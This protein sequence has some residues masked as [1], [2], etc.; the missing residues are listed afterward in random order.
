MSGEPL[1]Q[2]LT[3]YI[4]TVVAAVLFILAATPETPG[5]SDVSFEYRGEKY[6]MSPY[7][8]LFNNSPLGQART[9]L[10]V[11]YLKASPEGMARVKKAA[12][13]DPAAVW[14]TL[15]A[16]EK[17]TFLAVTAAASHLVSERSGSTLSWFERL[18]Q[19]HGSTK[20]A[21]GTYPNNQAF[22][23]YIRLSQTG[24][25]HLK[26]GGEFTNTCTKKKVKYGGMG[27]KHPD[28]CNP[29]KKFQ[30]QRPTNNSPRLQINVTDASGCADVDL[31]YD[32]DNDEHLTKDNSNVLGSHPD[33]DPAEYPPHPKIFVEQYCDLGFRRAQP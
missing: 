30:R 28:F 7:T 20:P 29:G 33:R 9:N 6:L 25:A 5:Q 21:G 23:L 32:Y 31:D 2:R 10:F 27:S 13:G 3:P 8:V 17:T 19:I 11:E 16:E 18:E 14:A 4:V 22:R 1:R 24:I 26:A 15:D 12:S